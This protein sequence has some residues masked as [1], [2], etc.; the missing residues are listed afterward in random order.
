MSNSITAT[1]LEEEPKKAVASGIEVQ[2]VLSSREEKINQ[3]AHAQ[4][5]NP[6]ADPAVETYYRNLYASVGY[7]C[8]KA[9]DPAMELTE[10]EERRIVLKLVA[11]SAC[12]MFASLQIDRGNIQQAVTDNMLGDLQQLQHRQHHFPSFSER[13]NE[14][15]L[16]MCIAPLFAVPLIGLIR[17]WP[18][19]GHKIWPTYVL[20]TLFLGQPYVLAIGASWCSRNSGSVRQRSISAAVYNMIGQIDNIIGIN[21]YRTDDLPLYHRGNMQLFFMTI[22]TIPVL[23][24]AKVLLRGKKPL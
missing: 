24:L 5:K 22:A 9:F 8:D 10:E 11:L 16:V 18:G 14:R 21:I 17:W 6:F 19:A 12:L 23:L 1:V 15:A 7:E 4:L 20:N 3:N 13:I 2:S